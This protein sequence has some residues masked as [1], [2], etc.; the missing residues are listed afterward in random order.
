MNKL[1]N[2]LRIIGQKNSKGGQ[3]SIL[4]HI[5]P[6]EAELLKMLGGS[7]RKDPDT[8]GIH[9]DEGVDG[10][11]SNSG[12]SP[13]SASQGP[14]N[15]G[16][17]SGYDENADSFNAGLSAAAE[18]L[19]GPGI[20]TSISD[21]TY[22]NNSYDVTGGYATGT[23]NTD[24]YNEVT[25][26][27][28]SGVAGGRGS[29]SVA[30]QS[31]SNYESDPAGWGNG[32]GLGGYNNM[33]GSVGRGEPG[34][35]DGFVGDMFGN[36]TSLN[37]NEF[38]S[39]LTQN[40]LNWAADL[41]PAA[42]GA[43]FGGPVG[44]F[45]GL[46]LGAARG[47]NITGQLAGAVGNAA[48]GPAGGFAAGLANQA[49]NGNYQGVLSGAI[50]AGLNATGNGLGQ[51]GYQNGGV[52][53]GMLGNY[54]QGAAVNGLSGAVI[55]GLS[56]FDADNNMATDGESF[57]SADSEFSGSGVG[58]LGPSFAM[59]SAEGGGGGGG[60]FGGG[61]LGGG[62]YGG[63]G[64]PSDFS[65]YDIQQGFIGSKKKSRYRAPNALTAM[66]EGD[67]YAA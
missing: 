9:F 59:A 60:D 3:D 15:D 8:G 21:E 25:G 20:S 62:S 27:L 37:A 39:W 16:G 42:L 67:E 36:R 6:H 49:Y 1:S 11:W 45:A 14:S 31:L 55:G 43:L 48:F 46:G 52:L 54:A 58:Y 53:G 13:D 24:T 18:S 29:G 40:D 57:G 4:A 66:L 19:G 65:N 51:Y 64:G 47:D 7:G 50:N 44:V 41:G 56:G 5:N 12:D 28:G 35:F 34:M 22:D 38:Q 17:N 26:D 63:G 23:T 32:G 10:G 30:D 2:I 33:S 61:G